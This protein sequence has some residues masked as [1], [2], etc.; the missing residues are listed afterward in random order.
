[1]LESRRWCSYEQLPH[2]Q[3][4]ADIFE[5][6]LHALKT[7]KQR[8]RAASGPVWQLVLEDLDELTLR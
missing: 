8:S 7:W 1:M 2:M 5:L 3:F 6:T 4:Q